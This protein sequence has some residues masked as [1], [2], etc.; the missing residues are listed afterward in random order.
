MRHFGKPC[1]Y[2]F[3]LV[4]Q[5]ACLCSEFHSSAASLTAHNLQPSKSVTSVHYWRWQE[6]FS[7]CVGARK[8]FNV[9]DTATP[10]SRARASV[11]RGSGIGLQNGSSGRNQRLRAPASSTTQ[12]DS[13][14]LGQRVRSRRNAELPNGRSSEKA[15]TRHSLDP[16]LKRKASAEWDDCKLTSR[17]SMYVTCF[18]VH[19][20]VGCSDEQARPERA[21]VT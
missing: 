17:Y 5:F 1:D 21:L 18:D 7:H 4:C 13:A 20:P 10:P 14:E 6:C 8:S 3:R 9:S 12:R 2:S 11:D 16:A 19:R 15:A